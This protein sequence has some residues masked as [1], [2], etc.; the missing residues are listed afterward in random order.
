ML[1]SEIE[2]DQRGNLKNTI[3]NDNVFFPGGSP[4]ILKPSR[5]TR[6]NV[7]IGSQEGNHGF[8]NSRN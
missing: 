1:I 7:S 4:G 5:N 3:E 2:G 8:S 6:S